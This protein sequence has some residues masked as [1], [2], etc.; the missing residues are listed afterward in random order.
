MIAGDGQ[1][2]EGALPVTVAVTAVNEG[3]EITL[4]DSYS[5][6]EGQDLTGAS[7]TARDPE[8]LA[9]TR[10]S[11]SG[12][13]RGDFSISEAGALTFRNTP[14]YDRPA[15]SNRDNE[16]LVTIRA[17]DGRY[18]GSLHVTITVTDVNEEAPVVTDRN[19]LSFRENTAITTRLY[20]YRA[21]DTDRNTVISWSVGG[22][23]GGLFEI[24]GGVLTRIHRRRV[25]VSPN[26]PNGVGRALEQ[27]IT[28]MERGPTRRIWGGRGR[29]WP[30]AGERSR[31]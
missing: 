1:G 13:D 18:Y 14:D 21:T 8:D 12:T 25:C 26:P 2:L 11:L 3:P 27:G 24:D 19:S 16:Y 28:G 20:T 31:S 9:I 6:A 7:F 23:N 17:S 30:V 5:V 15:D 29:Q 4:G 22:A 10:W